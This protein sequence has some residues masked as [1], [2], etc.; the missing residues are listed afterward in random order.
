M[1]GL[2][3]APPAPDT[4][5]IGGAVRPSTRLLW[6]PV[7]DEN[8]VGYKIYWRDTTSPQWQYSRFIDKSTTD[9]TLTN[10]V[11]DNYLFGVASV[12]KDGNESLVTYPTQLIPRRRRN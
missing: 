9:Y 8:L 11:I 7:D 2:A 3:S 6:N 5:M 1:A 12:G 10:I 4:V